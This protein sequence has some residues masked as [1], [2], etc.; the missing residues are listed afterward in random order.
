MP[1]VDAS[2]E[3]ARARAPGDAEERPAPSRRQVRAERASSPIGRLLRYGGLF[4]GAS[5]GWSVGGTFAARPE[6]VVASQVFFSA[7]LAGLGFLATP[8][9]VFDLVDAIVARLR[10]LTLDALLI[11]CMG[12][13]AGALFGLVLAW[14]LALLPRPAGQVVP[15]VVAILATVVGAL[16]ASSKQNELLALLGRRSLTGS[17]TLVLD[18]SALIDGRVRE[19]LRLGVLE[20]RVLVPEEVLRELHLLSEHSDPSR[21]ARGRRGLDLL[22]RMREELGSRLEVVPAPAPSRGADDAV[23]ACC[24]QVGGRI[25]TCDQ[26]LADL[27]RVRGLAVLNPNQVAEALRHPVAVGDRFSLRLVAE[28]RE[29]GQAVGY[30]DDGTLVVVERARDFLGRDVTVEVTRTLQTSSGRLVFGQVVQQ[31]GGR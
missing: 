14:P 7:V 17:G 12:A 18:T 27:A 20:G 5:I 21:R 23:L 6:L 2:H 4:V 3:T 11:G 1:I 29:E 31:D 22:R 13:F 16:V 25:V 24:S 28:G 19:L 9:I 30:L 26:R 8:Y 10:R 15:S